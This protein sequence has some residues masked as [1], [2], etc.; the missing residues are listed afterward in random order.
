MGAEEDD[1]AEPGS[2]RHSPLP[3]VALWVLVGILVLAIFAEA[4]DRAHP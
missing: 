2:P 1:Y 4:W 3:V